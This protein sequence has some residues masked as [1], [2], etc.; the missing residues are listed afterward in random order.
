[1][2]Q[3]GQLDSEEWCAVKV[4]ATTRKQPHPDDYS[5]GSAPQPPRMPHMSMVLAP[6]DQCNGKMRLS[7]SPRNPALPED[8]R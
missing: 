3:E 4:Q 8:E 2:A 6:V 7:R 5:G 1:M